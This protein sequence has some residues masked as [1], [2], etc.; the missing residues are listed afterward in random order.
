MERIP[1]WIS[2]RVCECVDDQSFLLG[3]LHEFDGS[4]IRIANINDAFA[5]VRTAR[6][7]L[8]FAGGFPT[9]CRNLFQNGVEIIY[10]QGNMR[11]SDIARPDIDPF[12]AFGREIF[13]QFDFVS[14][15]FENG[16]GNLRAGHTGDFLG[17][18]TGLMRAMRKLEAEHIAPESK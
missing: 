8:W 1:P 3:R 13:Q 12:S 16:E 9:G 10:R 15:S 2:L 4:S 6:E 7:R 14:R 18:F 11:R 5:G 17:K